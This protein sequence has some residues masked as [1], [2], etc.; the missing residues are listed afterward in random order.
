M[1]FVPEE[2]SGLIVILGKSGNSLL[3]KN[4][5]KIFLNGL[6]LW[7]FGALRPWSRR[8]T[9]KDPYGVG[10]SPV[11]MKERGSSSQYKAD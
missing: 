8:S 2:P 6:T 10:V 1:G 11:R 4:S 3:I 5:Q 7:K 9:P